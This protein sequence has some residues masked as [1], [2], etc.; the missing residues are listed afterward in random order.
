M[1]AH[2]R[3]V[4]LIASLR[5]GGTERQLVELITRSSAPERHTVA[6]FDEPG[7]LADRLPGRV[8]DIGPMSRRP[9]AGAATNLR[10]AL[11]FRR[12]VR[13]LRPDLVHAHLGL[14]EV[15]AALATPR[16]V[17][18]VAARRGRNVGFDATWWGRLAEGLGHR[19]SALLLCN[20]EDLARR[21]RERDL[22]TPPTRVIHNGIDAD[23]FRVAPMPEGAPRVVVVANMRARKGVDLF[24]RVFAKVLAEVPEA[25]ATIVGDG[26]DLADLRTLASDLAIA[27]A[28]TFT[29]AVPDPRPYVAAAHV[30]CLTS[31][32]EGF[33][34]ALLEAMCMGR[35]VVATAVGGIVELVRHATDGLLAPPDVDPLAGSLKDLLQDAARRSEMGAAAAERARRFA[36]ARVVTET[37]QAY[38]DVVAGSGGRP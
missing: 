35:P 15:L 31:A 25:T 13:E 30:V 1:S 7:P 32:Y 18:I 19:R 27:D 5:I 28:V 36:W 6:V 11:R 10:V 12:L 14:S 9:V 34:N 2:P 33:P 16:D 29:G 37:E 21:A 38:R 20:S 23:A 4:H 8:V 26:R 17:P 24:L 3:V 22:W